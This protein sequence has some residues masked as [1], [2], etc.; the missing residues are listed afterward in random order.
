MGGKWPKQWLYIWTNKNNLIKF[1]NFFWYW[2]LTL[3]P[4]P[5]ATLPGLLCG[6]FFFKVGSHELFSL[7]GLNWNSPDF[8][9]LSSWDY[10]VNP[11]TQQIFLL[12]SYENYLYLLDMNLLFGMCKHFL[13]FYN[14]SFY[15]P[16]GVVWSTHFTDKTKQINYFLYICAFTK[17]I[18]KF[19]MSQ[20]MPFIVS[21][22]FC[23]V[24]TFVKRRN[25]AFSIFLLL[26]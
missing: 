15:L 16:N 19:L 18:I 24:V 3:G 2:G 17:N 7:A 22:V 23:K 10:S 14:L 6:G 12:L 5:W 11:C 21:W 26:L 4:T 8:C 9:L 20:I 1:Y 13:L 25:Y